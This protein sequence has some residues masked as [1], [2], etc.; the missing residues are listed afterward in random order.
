MHHNRQQN[1]EDRDVNKRV[2]ESRNKCQHEDETCRLQ[3]LTL[4]SVDG[5]AKDDDYCVEEEQV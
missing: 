4:S 3:T 1:H 5:V 2:I